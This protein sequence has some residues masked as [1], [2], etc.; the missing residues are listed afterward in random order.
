M[1]F[2]YITSAFLLNSFANIFLKIDAL[3]T[4]LSEVNLLALLQHRMFFILGIILFALN[5]FFYSFAL[6]SIPLSVAYPIMVGASFLIVQ[7]Y[8][9]FSLGEKLSTTEIVG[10]LCV[11]LGLLLVSIS[12]K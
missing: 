3:R 2:L 5:V 8:A 9:Y 10:V 1:P 11:L 6:K 12:Q 4:P 7:L